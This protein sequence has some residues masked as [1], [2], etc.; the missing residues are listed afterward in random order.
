MHDWLISIA[1]TEMNSALKYVNLSLVVK[2]HV[3]VIICKVYSL[4]PS[5]PRIDFKS[6]ETLTRYCWGR[7]FRVIALKHRNST[8]IL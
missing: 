8:S 6:T 4:V 2:D 3:H 5:D 1:K 7:R